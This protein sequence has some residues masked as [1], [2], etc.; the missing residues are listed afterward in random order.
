[1]GKKD[2]GGAGA[3]AASPMARPWHCARAGREAP[4]V[5]Q[6]HPH[7]HPSVELY[8]RPGSRDRHGDR[9]RSMAAS[10]SPARK[11]ARWR[12]S[13]RPHHGQELWP[14]MQW[15]VTERGGRP[16]PDHEPR[17]RAFRGLHP[18]DGISIRRVSVR[19]WQGRKDQGATLS[20]SASASPASRSRT[21]PSRRIEERQ[22]RLDLARWSSIAP[23]VGP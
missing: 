2:V 15:T 11:S 13:A 16:L 19:L 10:V 8:D 14:E 7:A 4:D 21:A 23:H 20:W 22:R 6:H 17:G 1:M 12:T 5:A 18:S 9:L 3:R